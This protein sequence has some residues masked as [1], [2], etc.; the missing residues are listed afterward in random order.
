MRGKWPSYGFSD[1]E[2][3]VN[4]KPYKVVAECDLF[5]PDLSP[6]SG[7]TSYHN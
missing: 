4:G 7:D 6:S 2:L 5:D 1:G 3:I